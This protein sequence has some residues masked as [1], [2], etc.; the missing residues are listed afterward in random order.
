MS[1]DQLWALVDQGGSL[2]LLT[3]LIWAISQRWLMPGWYGANLE[4]EIVRLQREVDE[5]RERAWA[6]ALEARHALEAA[7]W[8]S[9][10]DGQPPPERP[11]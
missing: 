11:V 9:G 5:W 1:W 7:G 6:S 2:L 10:R 4:Q 3:L 8:R